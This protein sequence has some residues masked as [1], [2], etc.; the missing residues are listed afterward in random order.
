METTLRE[1]IIVESA[2]LSRLVSGSD[3]YRRYAAARETI[4]GDPGLTEKIAEYKRLHADY[5]D[6]ADKYGFYHFD[7][8]K[9]ISNL[10][11]ELMMHETAAEY[12][13]CESE[14]AAVVA[15]AVNGIAAGC[16]LDL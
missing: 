3:L 7:T 14:L 4:A 1:K 9:Y 6:K 13:L 8:E 16:P 10:Y 15:E 11:W 12:L 2:R 5:R